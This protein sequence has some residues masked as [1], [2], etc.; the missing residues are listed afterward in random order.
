[1]DYHRQHAEQS[2]AIRRVFDLQNHHQWNVRA[3]T[4][5]QRA[6]SLLRLKE[7]I[8]RREPE[9]RF[10]LFQDLRK[11]IDGPSEFSFLHEIDTTVAQLAQWMQDI[12]LDP[13]PEFG[14][15]KSF[16]TY[17]PKGVVLLFGPWNF[18]FALVFQPLV[19]IIAAGNCAIV[20]PNEM[21]P[22]TSRIT[23]Q[24][25]R[26]VFP[27]NEVA[28]F[29]GNV[30]LANALL[31]LPFD[32][33]F[34]TG[35]PKVGRA[36]M[37]AAASHLASVTLELGGK[38]PAVVDGTVD[39]REAAKRIALA[40]S[41]NAGQICLCPDYVFV[42]ESLQSD[43]IT[44][45][46][47]AIQSTF[48]ANGTIDK[49]AYEKIIDDRN[50]ARLEG[51]LRDAVARGARIELGGEADPNDRTFHPTILTHV[52]PESAI[53]QEETFGPILPVL[54]YKHPEEVI[55]FIRARG[56]PLALYVFSNDRSFIEHIV[57]NT[58][59][60]GV[61]VNDCFSHCRDVRLPFGGVNTS[62]IGRYHGIHG[63]KELSHER[64]IFKTHCGKALE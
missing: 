15:A 20:K 52:A 56:K 19:A 11:P 25:I 2:Q 58:S 14:T 51:Y 17:E 60:G 21:A 43:F 3:R 8:R 53:L 31:E 40:R 36:V 16:I 49:E 54:T 33:I 23:A 39:L 34:F 29:E 12:E 27:E 10:A 37:V 32:H 44:H 48:Y 24:I 61:T 47:S 1:M 45:L 7:C 35:S 46:K 57:Q 50:F 28:V 41:K 5:S 6:A 59:S 13:L 63:F 4:A 64:A 30:E 38:N 9:I 42:P 62:G 55:E 18:P 22:A 26:E